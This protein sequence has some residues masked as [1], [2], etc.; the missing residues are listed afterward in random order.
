MGTNDA[1]ERVVTERPGI[2]PMTPDPRDPTLLPVG[3][4]G[5]PRRPAESRPAACPP[6]ATDPAAWFAWLD[7]TIAAGRPIDAVAG[8]ATWTDGRGRGW[9]VVVTTEGLEV[10]P[11]F[12]S[13]FM[14]ARDL[15]VISAILVSPPLLH[16][17]LSWRTGQEVAR[18][19]T[20]EVSVRD[21]GLAML[22]ETELP[23]E[24]IGRVGADTWAR[25]RERWDQLVGRAEGSTVS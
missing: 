25:A 23:H 21:L 15:P 2:P 10:R 6:F 13:P 19:G 8:A 7:G 3:P 24:A 11:A 17:E 18:L 9:R 1:E 16:V 20:D 22:T 4:G 14:V 12:G 5:R